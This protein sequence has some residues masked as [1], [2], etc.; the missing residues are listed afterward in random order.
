MGKLETVSNSENNQDLT[1]SNAT[2]VIVETPPLG[3]DEKSGQRCVSTFLILVCFGGIET[4]VNC[5]NEHACCGGLFND[6]VIKKGL[7]VPCV[8]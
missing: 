4:W 5:D 7:S 2:V 3:G 1:S 8:G 6:S